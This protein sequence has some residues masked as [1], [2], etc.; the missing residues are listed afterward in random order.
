M[1][2]VSIYRLQNFFLSSESH[3][4]EVHVPSVGVLHPLSTPSHCHSEWTSHLHPSRTVY[5]F[6]PPGTCVFHHLSIELKTTKGLRATS[7]F[8][9]VTVYKLLI[10]GF[11]LFFHFNV[12]FKVINLLRTNTVNLFYRLK[13]GFHKITCLQSDFHNVKSTSY[14]INELKIVYIYFLINQ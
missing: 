14:G 8:Q 11:F 12:I 7:R 6:H 1:S 3:H 13:N 4:I 9:V 2:F 5:I 10:I